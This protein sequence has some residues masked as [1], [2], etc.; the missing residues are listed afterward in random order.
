MRLTRDR[1]IAFS[2][3]FPSLVLVGLFVYGFIGNTI[4]IS[5][6]DW[7]K[8]AALA[9]NPE[10][11]LVG[12]ENYKELFTGFL[13]GRFRQDLINAF[14]YTLTL[15]IGSLVLGLLLAVLLDREPR[16]ESIFRTIFLYPM[17]LSFVVTGTIWRW[18]LAPGG[19]INLLPSFVGLPKSNFRWLSSRQQILTFDW[20][21]L[22][23]ITAIVVGLVLIFLAFGAWRKGAR[24]RASIIAIPAGLLILWAFFG[25]R[26]V[27]QMVP[28]PERHGFNLATI[29]VS[30]AAIWQFSGYTMALYLAGLRGIPVGLHEAARLDG[31]SDIQY[32]LRVAFPILKPIT[33]SAVIILAHISLKMFALIFAMAGPDNASTCHPAVL[34]YLTTFR[35]NKFALG[36]SIAVILFLIVALFIIPYLIGSY[37]EQRG[38]AS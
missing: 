36:A 1:I 10:M 30:L 11:H 23:A 5:L 28:F 19:G 2:V 31:A 35:G 4:Y 29:G 32:Y 20:Q 15:V 17:A 24:R 16:G 18:L 8:G 37:R 12:F 3:L 7:G 27:P 33:L 38:R 6:T 22:P 9:E 26:M 13:H 34:M 14:F 25:Q 21:S